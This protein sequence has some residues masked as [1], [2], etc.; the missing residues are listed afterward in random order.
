M[1]VT[2]YQLS[3][4]P[5]GQGSALPVQSYQKVIS[6]REKDRKFSPSCFLLFDFW[7]TVYY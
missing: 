1:T 3:V 2:S 6:N 7:L 5:Y 4:I